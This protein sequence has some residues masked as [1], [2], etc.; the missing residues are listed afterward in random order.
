MRRVGRKIGFT[1]GQGI[2]ITAALI[3]TYAIFAQDF[4][5]FAFG[6][7][8]FGIHNAFWQYYRFA[9]ADTASEHFRSKAISYVM[10]GGV[11]GAFAGP[12]I[13]KNSRALFERSENHQSELPHL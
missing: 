11:I 7:A 8:L 3:A 6:S 9:A 2:G 13:A 12:A 4:W 5:L 10:A 1:L